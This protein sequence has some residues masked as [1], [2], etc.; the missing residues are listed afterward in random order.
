MALTKAEIEAMI[1][2]AENYA[3]IIMANGSRM[4]IMG[5]IGV[6][7]PKTGN[8]Q[9]IPGLVVSQ[10]RGIDVQKDRETRGKSKSF[11]Y[12]SKGNVRWLETIKEIGELLGLD[13]ESTHYYELCPLDFADRLRKLLREYD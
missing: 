6:R 3:K 4:T 7:D 9:W 8:E 1:E 2:A 11:G 10:M 12:S 5:Q 13:Y